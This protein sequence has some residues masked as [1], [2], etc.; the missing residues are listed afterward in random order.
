MSSPVFHEDEFNRKAKE[1]FNAS[2]KLNDSWK[3]N[4]KGGKFYLT[5]KTIISILS[6]MNENVEP[7]DDDPS[8]AK[9]EMKEDLISMEYQVLFHPSFQTP[10]L[11]FNALNSGKIFK[12]P[13]RN[14]YEK[15][16]NFKFIPDGSLIS[17]DD[18]S[19]VFVC[20]YEFN[21]CHNEMQNIITQAEHPILFKPYFMLHPCQVHSVL[22]NFQDSKNF[23]LTFLT[24]YGPSIQ[25]KMNQNYEKLI[26]G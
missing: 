19:K 23:V 5:K 24:L 16:I 18:L 13:D 4:E 7:S 14:S 6:A 2:E 1:F 10:A 11:Y 17:L 15:L 3:L 9:P 22:S 8:V 12:K 20:Q 21:N 26:V 25:L